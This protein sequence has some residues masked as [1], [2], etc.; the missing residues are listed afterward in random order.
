MM[1]DLAKGE[2]DAGVLWGPM[3]G[4]YAK[5]ANPPL[6]VTPLVKETTGPK[7]IYRI[8]MGVRPADQNWKRQLNRLIQENQGEINKI[9]LDYG[10]PLLDENDRPIGPDTAAK[11]P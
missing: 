2:I 10:V 3:A 11:S 8:G 6:H 7:L 5:E 1:K 4:F 9:L